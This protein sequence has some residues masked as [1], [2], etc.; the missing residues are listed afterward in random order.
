MLTAEQIAL[1]TQA[2]TN[3]LGMIERKMHPQIPQQNRRLDALARLL[4]GDDV[5][6]AVCRLDEKKY[7]LAGNYKNADAQK[8]LKQRTELLITYLR[9]YP[10]A[11]SSNARS[12]LLKKLL[13]PQIRERLKNVGLLNAEAQRL[14]TELY[15][16]ISNSSEVRDAIKAH[17][18]LDPFSIDFSEKRRFQQ[19]QNIINACLQ[20]YE[21]QQSFFEGLLYL[22]FRGLRD[23]HK[24]EDEVTKHT[25]SSYSGTYA[26]LLDEDDEINNIDNYSVARE[27]IAA[28]SIEYLPSIDPGIH[29]EIRV[30][31]YLTAYRKKSNAAEYY[32]GISRTCCG[33]CALFIELHN[34][35]LSPR[36]AFRGIHGDCYPWP[37][38]N[39]Q[40][41]TLVL[42][43]CG[44]FNNANI[45]EVD[46][47][48]NLA[49][50]ADII[51][52]TIPQHPYA[53]QDPRFR[54]RNQHPSLSDSDPEH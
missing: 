13:T 10:S 53:G 40:Q 50:L 39:S 22:I 54:C 33:K 18:T 29:A 43:L 32:L 14:F 7:I 2:Y 30:K 24:L 1:F 44:L 11:T 42:Q 38:T 27:I 15:L 41:K 47:Q 46:I 25:T 34:Q 6:V 23:L 45:T 5:C 51:S 9:N 17:E 19:A 37:I 8:A 20:A 16:I 49:I 36:L 28:A 21:V 31:Q 48:D 35:N 12:D 26:A 52:T 4:E 3:Q